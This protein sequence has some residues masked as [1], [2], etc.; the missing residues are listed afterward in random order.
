[1]AADE[2]VDEPPLVRVHVAFEGRNR[3]YD[4]LAR[5]YCAVVHRVLPHLATLSGLEVGGDVCFGDSEKFVSLCVSVG[6]PVT[7]PVRYVEFAVF[8]DLGITLFFEISVVDVDRGSDLDGVSAAFPCFGVVVDAVT[9]PVLTEFLDFPDEV[10]SVFVTA[11]YQFAFYGVFLVA[12]GAN[13]QG[14]PFEDVFEKTLD[15]QY[16]HVIDPSIET[17]PIVKTPADRP[18]HQ[19]SAGAEKLIVTPIITQRNPAVSNASEF[20]SSLSLFRRTTFC[21]LVFGECIP[22]V[23]P[24]E[25]EFEGFEYRSSSLLLRIE[26]HV[27]NLLQEMYEEGDRTADTDYKDNPREE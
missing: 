20:P 12:D 19:G 16:S 17:I 11:L 27:S 7:D 4:V 3:C 10:G 15:F 2:L 1:M 8:P 13:Q 14:S 18:S 6:F 21:S 5:C 26:H 9:V 22:P 25:R 24:D 23:Q